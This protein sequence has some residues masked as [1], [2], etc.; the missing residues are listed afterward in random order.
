MRGWIRLL[1]IVALL[2]LAAGAA[3]VWMQR[4]ALVDVVEVRYAPLV[5]SL[6]FSARV[7]A[8]SRVD[9]GSTLTG[10]VERVLVTEGAQV[11]QGA[12]L[13]ELESR[14]LR[15][16]L[17]QAQASV[18]QARARLAGLRSTGRDTAQAGVAQAQAALD[19]AQAEFTRVQQLVAQGFLSASRQDDARRARGVAAAQ[20][21]AAGTQAQAIGQI[22]VPG[23]GD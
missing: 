20:R 11:Q 5:R 14:E 6:Q 16:A 9:V 23:G 12:V 4:P 1:V 8:L 18:S 10:R 22:G 2:V 15:A 7:E 17:A 19:A 3:A 13:V 21:D